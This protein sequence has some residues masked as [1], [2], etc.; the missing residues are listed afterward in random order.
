[1]YKSQHS[2]AILSHCAIRYAELGAK[3]CNTTEQN[4]ARKMQ[5]MWPANDA[6]NLA[7][8]VTRWPGGET[9][10]LAGW[11]CA[12]ENGNRKTP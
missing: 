7:K 3:S 10:K 4:L 8:D 11:N 9:G 5:F 12:K 1:M 6:K 2:L